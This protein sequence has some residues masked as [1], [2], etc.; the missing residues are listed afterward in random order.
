VIFLIPFGIQSFDLEYLFLWIAIAFAE[1]SFWR[2]MANKQVKT[3][4]KYLN[5]Y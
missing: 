2:N 3:Y 4:L 5:N 1:S